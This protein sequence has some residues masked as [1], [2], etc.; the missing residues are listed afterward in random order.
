MDDLRCGPDVERW[1][2]VFAG[3]ERV[4]DASGEELA[5]SSS[6]EVDTRGLVEPG[7]AFLSLTTARWRQEISSPSTSI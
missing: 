2:R 3:T 4:V 5:V 6:L 1:G 7:D